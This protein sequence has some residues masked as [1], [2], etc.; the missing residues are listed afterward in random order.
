MEKQSY[1]VDL[2]SVLQKDAE[3]SI[4]HVLL[5]WRSHWR[6]WEGKKVV[7]MLFGPPDHDSMHAMPCLLDYLRDCRNELSSLTWT[8][9]P[10]PQPIERGKSAD[11]VCTWLDIN[12][13]NIYS[14]FCAVGQGEIIFNAWDEA[15]EKMLCRSGTSFFLGVFAWRQAT[16]TG[17]SDLRFSI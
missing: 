17:L 6:E 15:G 12:L 11:E 8:F 2:C 16:R 9:F 10:S 7:V 13:F 4:F 5:S 14:T 1:R 3:H